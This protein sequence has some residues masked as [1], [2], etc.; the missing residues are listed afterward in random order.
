ML[1][2][3]LP[4]VLWTYHPLGVVAIAKF[5]ILLT[6]ILMAVMFACIAEGSEPNVIKG[7][8]CVQC[9]AA[10]SRVDDMRALHACR[11][12]GRLAEEVHVCNSCDD[13]LAWLA[14]VG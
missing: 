5:C 2:S 8:R 7:Y 10:C 4:A 1:Q 11:C 3:G 6:Y 12:T 9:L 13:A 14:N